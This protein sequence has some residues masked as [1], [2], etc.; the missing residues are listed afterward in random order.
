MLIFSYIFHRMANLILIGEYG[1]KKKITLM[2]ILALTLTALL[3]SVALAAGNGMLTSTDNVNANIEKKIQAAV[4]KADTVYNQYQAM[5]N[6]VA[7]QCESGVISS[8][9]AAQQLDSCSAWYND[10]I[11]DI[12]NKLVK[13]T[14]SLAD[15]HAR[16]AL[17]S[18]IV[19]SHEYISVIIAG[20]TYL[21]DPI[22]IIGR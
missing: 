1:V 17:N 5:I 22:R 11:E 4:D 3:S 15:A 13:Q 10:Q 8:T 9:Q 6:D 20:N 12:V 14:D 7:Q 16:A 2:V 21:I 18:G 19:V